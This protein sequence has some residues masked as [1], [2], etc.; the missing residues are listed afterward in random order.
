MQVSLFKIPMQISR[1]W[2]RE[3]NFLN[4]TYT[5]PDELT[6]EQLVGQRMGMNLMLEKHHL[7]QGFYNSR[8]SLEIH[9][10]DKGRVTNPLTASSNSTL[11][12]PS[13][14]WHP[15]RQFFLVALLSTIWIVTVGMLIRKESIFRKLLPLKVNSL[16]IK[17]AAKADWQHSFQT[18]PAP[19][20]YSSHNHTYGTLFTISKHCFFLPHG[21]S[22]TLANSRQAAFL[23]PSD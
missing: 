8:A 16:F 4:K 20:E 2:G 3:I 18:V 11:M 21:Y 6:T 9:H 12:Q 13:P 1:S 10:G 5:Q 23:A 15:G 14:L 7:P 22:A 19:S 17:T